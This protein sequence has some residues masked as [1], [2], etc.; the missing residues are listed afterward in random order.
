MVH[1]FLLL[2]ISKYRIIT[3]LNIKLKIFKQ[4]FQHIV[5]YLKILNIYILKLNYCVTTI[6]DTESSANHYRK[7][8]NNCKG[9]L[10]R[11]EMIGVLY[12]CIFDLFKNELKI[13]SVISF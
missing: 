2:L 1:C 3:F 8:K 5:F 13:V 11:T 12:F 9:E 4:I 6:Y 10:V 7:M